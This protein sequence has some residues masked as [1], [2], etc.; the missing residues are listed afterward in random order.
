[1]ERPEVFVVDDEKG[2]TDLCTDILKPD[3][4]VKTFLSAKDALKEFDKEQGPDVIVTDIKMPVMDGTEFT[5]RLRNRGISCPIIMMSAFIEKNNALQA[6]ENGIV[7]MIEK[8]FEPAVLKNLVEKSYAAS[9]TTILSEKTIKKYDLLTNNL[10]LLV[11]EY[12]KRLYETENILFE[13]R[14]NHVL[15][16]EAID[17]LKNAQKFTKI[18]DSSQV[19]SD[20]ITEL[21][22]A[23][24]KLSTSQAPHLSAN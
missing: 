19:F 23:I 20:E 21:L 3:F 9:R 11:Q 17:Y 16:S 13:F 10:K 1:M 15:T 14:G 18:E 22:K 12:R 5:R 2:I 7:G 8:P 24:E 4:G 6:F